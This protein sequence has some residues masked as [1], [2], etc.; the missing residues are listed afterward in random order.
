[1][2]ILF[3]HT[4]G[5]RK[6]GGGERWVVNAASGLQRMGHDVTVISKKDSVLLEKVAGQG[7]AVHPVNIFSDVSLYHAVKLSR[8]MRRHQFDIIISKRWDLA[9]TGLAAKLAGG[10]PVVVRTGVPPQKSL[11]KHV[12]LIKK[13]AVGLITNTTTIRDVYTSLAGFPD[14]F[15][16]VIYNGV[17]FE[18]KAPAF[19]FQKL[20]PGKKV[21]LCAGRLDA[22]QKGYFVLIEALSIVKK[23]HPDVMVYVLGTGRDRDKLLEYARSKGVNDSIVFAGYTDT[24]SVY[25]KACDVFLHTALFEG[26]PNAVMEAMAYARPVVMTDVNGAAE[27][28]DHG[29]YAVLIPPSDPEKTAVALSEVLSSPGRYRQM[30]LDAKDFVRKQFSMDAMLEQLEYLLEEKIHRHKK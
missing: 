16:K 7:G 11:K 12:L 18:D 8:F 27:L 21:V 17:S 15:I 22:F 6:F 24:P 30:A 3:V 13:L 10:L 23:H 14:D 25:M 26:M 1:M 19:D 9:V 29:K 4:I 2:K 20:F 28:S 5:K